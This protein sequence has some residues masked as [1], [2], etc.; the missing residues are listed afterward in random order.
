[1]TENLRIGKVVLGHKMCEAVV[2][3]NKFDY[4]KIKIYSL[5]KNTLIKEKGKLH[6]RRHI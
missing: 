6:M 3:I 4:M 1:M 2:K 5:S